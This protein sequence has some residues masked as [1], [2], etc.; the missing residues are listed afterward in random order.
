[1]G[2]L[3]SKPAQDLSVIGK[4]VLLLLGFPELRISLRAL[5]TADI[6]ER[7]LEGNAASLASVCLK[8]VLS[9]TKRQSTGQ[10]Y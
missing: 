6:S 7:G 9:L 3:S 1:M 5:G 10:V 2:F 4:L 8:Q